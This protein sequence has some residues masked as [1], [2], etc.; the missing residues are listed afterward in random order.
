M[1]ADLKTKWGL[2]IYSGLNIKRLCR[3]RDLHNAERPTVCA[4][5]TD[6]NGQARD[7]LMNSASEKKNILDNKNNSAFN[8]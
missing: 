6:K 5:I 3:K 4:F 8:C 7:F 2:V 1:A